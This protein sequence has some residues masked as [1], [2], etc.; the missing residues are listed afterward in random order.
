MKVAFLDRDGVINYNYGYVGASERF[1]LLPGVVEGL[2]KLKRAGFELI[3]I[4]N[5][6]GI[7]RGYF[8]I[9]EYRSLTD[10]YENML[11]KSGVQFLEI[12]FCPHYQY[13]EHVEYR[14]EC[15][16]RKPKPG[17]IYEAVRKYD[18]DLSDSILVGDSLTDIQAGA[19]ANVGSLYFLDSGNSNNKNEIREG[20]QIRFKTVNSL[21]QVSQFYE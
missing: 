21:L 6:S 8:T 11:S 16:C 20:L 12:Y 3:I 14:K 4:T 19:V 9:N 17:M 2:L 5:Q 18:I 13:S 10:Y 15:D 1:E 7:G